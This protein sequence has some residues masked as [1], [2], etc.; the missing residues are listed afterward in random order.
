MSAPYV[1]GVTPYRES[2]PKP[3]ARI[4][5][6]EDRVRQMAIC[7]R[8]GRPMR[9]WNGV[10]IYALLV[11]ACFLHPAPWDPLLVGFICIVNGRQWDTYA[12]DFQIWLDGM[13]AIAKLEAAIR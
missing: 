9:P 11:V 5:I 3:T 10:L 13:R 1:N 8:E 4:P 12:K 6:S 2:A 7:I